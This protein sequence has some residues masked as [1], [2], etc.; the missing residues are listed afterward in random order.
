MRYLVTLTYESLKEIS[1]NMFQ[2]VHDAEIRLVVESINPEVAIA[3]AVRT[4]YLKWGGGPTQEITQ[5]DS[6]LLI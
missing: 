1:P 2:A 3:R 4:V 5:V 6:V